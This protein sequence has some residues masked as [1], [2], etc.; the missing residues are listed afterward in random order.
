[1][2]END[3]YRDNRPAQP[4][5]GEQPSY[6]EQPLMP[7]QP[8]PQPDPQSSQ[9]QNPQGQPYGQPSYGQQYGQP[10][11]GQPQYGQQSGF[12]PT[13]YGAAALP[14]HPQAMTALV[15]GIVSLAGAMACILPIFCAPFA[16]YYGRKAVKEIDAE[17][18][19]YSG[20]S[21]AMGGMVTGIIGTVG[22]VLLIVL[23]FIIIGIVAVGVSESGFTEP[24]V[25]GTPT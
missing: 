25:V 3:P 20:R 22:L 11:Y 13:A 21:E 17:P 15:L 23:V 4:P 9:G 10:Q 2:S 18:Q 16:W 12:Q 5:Y 8:D 24:G 14:K 1:M 6:G 7:P 19:R